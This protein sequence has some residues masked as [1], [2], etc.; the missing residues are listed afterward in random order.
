MTN[1]SGW[2]A[3]RAIGRKRWNKRVSRAIGYI[4]TLTTFDTLYI[5]GGNAKYI[6]FD[7]PTKVQVV[8]NQAGIT[9][10][11]KLWGPLLDES[12]TNQDQAVQG[13]LEKF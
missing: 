3:L 8:S 7:L 11:V 9:G 13:A 2:P 1:I 10:G 4:E 6:S 12:F 5:G